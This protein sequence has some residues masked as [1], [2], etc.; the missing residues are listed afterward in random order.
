MAQ[1]SKPNWQAGSA[2]RAEHAAARG[3]E[4]IA[5]SSAEPICLSDFEP[6]A[7]AKMPAM[8]GNM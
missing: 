3:V 1:D 2:T 4:P 7:K 6:L 8:A 5:A